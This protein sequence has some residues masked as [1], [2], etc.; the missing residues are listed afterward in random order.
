MIENQCR[1]MLGNDGGSGQND[2][3]GWN[4][5]KKNEKFRRTAK[6]GLVLLK[7]QLKRFLAI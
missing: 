3:N 6:H 2:A 5:P 1:M 7:I 4:K